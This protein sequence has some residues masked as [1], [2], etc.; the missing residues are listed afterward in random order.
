MFNQCEGYGL[1]ADN[2]VGRR[3]TR[4]FKFC[5]LWVMRDGE[6]VLKKYP[7]N[8]LGMVDLKLTQQRVLNETTLKDCK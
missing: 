1:V 6:D 7:T 5:G 4:R 8:F 3:R 2:S